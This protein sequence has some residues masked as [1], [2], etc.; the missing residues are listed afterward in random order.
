MNLIDHIV[1]LY[2]DKK[3]EVKWWWEN[4]WLCPECE[5]LG[6]TDKDVKDLYDPCWACD[7]SGHKIDYWR[8]SWKVYWLE[9]IRKK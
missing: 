4:F 7:R 2:G 8:A 1:M 6:E 5:G 9:K 3:W